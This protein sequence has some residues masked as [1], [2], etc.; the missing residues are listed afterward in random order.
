MQP[1]FPDGNRPINKDKK[2]I[3]NNSYQTDQVGFLK[4]FWGGG[5]GFLWGFFSGRESL[6][7]CFSEVYAAVTL[8]G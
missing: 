6:S 7:S 8:V 4:I 2:F 3:E 1:I 5:C